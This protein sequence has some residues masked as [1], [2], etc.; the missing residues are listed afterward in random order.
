MTSDFDPL[1]DTT[2][3]LLRLAADAWSSN[4][5][6]SAERLARAAWSMFEGRDFVDLEASADV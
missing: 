3:K 5:L 1:T 2:I 6:C 4:A